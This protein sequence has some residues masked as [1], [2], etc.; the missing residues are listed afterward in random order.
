MNNLTVIYYTSNFLED[1]NP[2]FLKNTLRQLLI[3]AEGLPIISVS[4]KPMKLG[5]NICMGDIG[6]SHLNIYK[7]ILE[8][9]K[10]AKTE[11]VAMAEDD[12]LYSKE[13][14]DFKRYIKPEI[15]KQDIFMYDMN[16]VS[17]FTWSNPPQFSFR[18]KRKVVN[19]LICKRKLLI[20]ALEERF[21]RVEELLL[22]RPIEKIIKYW[23]DPGRYENLLGVTPRKSYEWYSWTP[24]IVFSHEHAYGYLSQGKKKKKGDLRIIELVDWGRAEDILKLY[25]ES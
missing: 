24:S 4:Q 10:A 14:F 19:Q 16:K 3:A 20:E 22:D 6:R 21:L 13:H 15:Y 18:T 5:K 11:Y 1:T 12:I 25:Y 9:C 17:L 7:Q 23:G 2:Y 8:G